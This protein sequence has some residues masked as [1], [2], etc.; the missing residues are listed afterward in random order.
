MLLDKVK[1]RIGFGLLILLLLLPMFCN[2]LGN[3]GEQLT[4]ICFTFDVDLDDRVLLSC[5]FVNQSSILFF[6]VSQLRSIEVVLL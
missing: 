5:V 2:D 6:I 3:I 1:R 4:S